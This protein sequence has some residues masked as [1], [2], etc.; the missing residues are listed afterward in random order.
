MNPQV[1][2]ILS[3]VLEAASKTLDR[4]T[5]DPRRLDQI[6]RLFDDVHTACNWPTDQPKRFVNEWTLTLMTMLRKI[7]RAGPLGYGDELNR[8]MTVGLSLLPFIQRDG[9][10]AM[11]VA[12]HAPTSDHDFKA[13]I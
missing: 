12:A 9:F 13:R 8:A 11:K 10:D 3:R 1:P 6:E 5:G 7:E 4:P 2:G